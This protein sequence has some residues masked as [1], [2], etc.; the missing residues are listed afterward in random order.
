[1]AIIPGEILYGKLYDLSLAILPVKFIAISLIALSVLYFLGH[2]I[3][4]IHKIVGKIL[5]LPFSLILLPLRLIGLMVKV[6]ID[7]F[8][9]I[10]IPFIFLLRIVPLKMTRLLADLMD[11]MPVGFTLSTLLGI[12]IGSFFGFD[13]ARRIILLIPAGILPY[14]LPLLMLWISVMILAI[15]TYRQKNYVTF[16]IILFTLLMPILPSLLVLFVI[17]SSAIILSLVLDSPDDEV[18]QNGDSQEETV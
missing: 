11:D 16:V 12:A 15:Y 8:P 3:S 2:A 7:I 18:I 1:L 14:I 4:R 6:V 17:T 5:S 13:L 9:F 10:V